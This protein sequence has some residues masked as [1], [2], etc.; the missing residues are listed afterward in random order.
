MS[1][2]AKYAVRLPNQK[3]L[4]R[5]KQI[6]VEMNVGEHLGNRFPVFERI[7]AWYGKKLKLARTFE[8]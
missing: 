3:V 1:I 7:V 6:S 4:G 5:S 2:C 8:P